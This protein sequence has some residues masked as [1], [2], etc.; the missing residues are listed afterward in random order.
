MAFTKHNGSTIKVCEPCAMK[1]AN[2]FITGH[3]YRLESYK[4]RSEAAICQGCG[5]IFLRRKGVSNPRKF[6]DRKNCQSIKGIKN[7]VVRFSTMNTGKP[8]P[9]TADINYHGKPNL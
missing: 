1:Y 8:T 2:K 9:Y 5:K 4:I 3:G 6:C 7:S